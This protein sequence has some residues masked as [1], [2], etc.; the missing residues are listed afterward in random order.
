MPD[1]RFVARRGQ[2]DRRE[3]A[4]AEV[5]FLAGQDGEEAGEADLRLHVGCDRDGMPDERNEMLD[6]GIVE[7]EIAGE[8]SVGQGVRSEEHTSELQT[9]MRNSDAVVCLK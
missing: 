1:L 4:Q 9:L 3:A 7:D 8:G 6:E 5:V 2:T